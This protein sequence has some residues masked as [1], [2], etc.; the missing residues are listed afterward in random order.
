[1]LKIIFDKINLE[2]RLNQI[3]NIRKIL[4]IP[5]LFIVGVIFAYNYLRFDNFFENGSSY[6]L[7]A[8]S[9]KLLYLEGLTSNFVNYFFIPPIVG[10]QFPY[11]F[12]QFW[13]PS[14]TIFEGREKIVGII[15]YFPMIL[16]PLF[17]KTNNP[18]IKSIFSSFEFKLISFPAILNLICLLC[19][20]YVSMRYL[21]DFIGLII[22]SVFYIIFYLY[23]KY[24]SIPQKIYYLNI[25]IFISGL[26]TILC[27]LAFS[28]TGENH[29]LLFQ[30]PELF[31]ELDSFFRINSH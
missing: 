31:K 21:G 13:Q 15:C 10:S 12:T 7:A 28:I 5:F 22:L 3:V 19:F 8:L 17:F 11:L 2:P 27:S 20:Q 29:G 16:I 26:I 30:N 4:F 14:F 18:C 6:V 1:M 9:P 23:E 24:S 25:L